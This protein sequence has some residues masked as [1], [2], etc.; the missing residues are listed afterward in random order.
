MA[1]RGKAVKTAGKVRSTRS[2]EIT[3]IIIIISSILH[4]ISI[5]YS[6]VDSSRGT[7]T[8]GLEYLKNQ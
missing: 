4:Q 1:G 6:E 5:S 8:R 2:E 7:D 3:T